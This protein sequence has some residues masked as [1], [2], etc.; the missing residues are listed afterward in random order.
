MQ[1][2]L[3]RR[4]HMATGE[5]QIDNGVFRVTKWT[6]EPNDAI[7]MHVHE[8]EYVVVP[9]VND[10]MQVRT[11]DGTEV[12]AEI[13][14]GESYAR[15]TGAEHTVINPGPRTIEFVEIEKLV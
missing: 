10:V 2:N 6:I 4:N 8:F 13:H 3:K 12:S 11:V 15:P 9:L 5:T 14:I 7:P 1:Y